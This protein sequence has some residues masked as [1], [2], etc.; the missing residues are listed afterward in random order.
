MEKRGYKELAPGVYINKDYVIYD[1]RNGN[2]K[3]DAKGNFYFIDVVTK[4]NTLKPTGGSRQYG[5]GE[6]LTG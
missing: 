3:L 4:L 1:V 2:V 6:L 5:N